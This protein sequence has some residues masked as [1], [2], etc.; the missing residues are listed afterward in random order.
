[1]E[2]QTFGGCIDEFFVIAQFIELPA[3]VL[4]QPGPLV[5]AQLVLPAK[6]SGARKNFFEYVG[7]PLLR[8]RLRGI[9]AIAGG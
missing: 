2:D 7:Q 8:H 3:E 1:M 4:A 5:P 6:F 9:V